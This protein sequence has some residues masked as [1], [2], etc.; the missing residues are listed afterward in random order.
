MK[1]IIICLLL[2]FS[3][4][5]KPYSA[6]AGEDYSDNKDSKAQGI[7]TDDG[8]KKGKKGD[9]ESGEVIYD[10]EIDTEIVPGRHERNM[11]EL[12]KEWKRLRQ[13]K[14]KLEKL[15]KKS[16]KNGGKLTQKEEEIKETVIVEIDFLES[17]TRL[18]LKW[19][20]KKVEKLEKKIKKNGKLTQREE[21]IK[22]RVIEEINFLENFPHLLP[23]MPLKRGTD[24]KGGKRKIK[25]DGK[26]TQEE[27]EK[28]K[29]VF[30]KIDELASNA[31]KIAMDYQQNQLADKGHDYSFGPEINA[32][33]G[34]V[35]GNIAKKVVGDLFS[36]I[37]GG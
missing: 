17:S 14:K 18:R 29:R 11:M 3:V 13:M 28:K 15:E 34:D 24:K 5:S 7:G 12:R 6:E 19:L 4:Y 2:I 16:K 35:V 37:F 10:E 9:L 27:E 8:K 33:I 32:Q 23:M 1:I 22:E 31:T 30:E 21:E 25:K 20:D 26:T 36:K